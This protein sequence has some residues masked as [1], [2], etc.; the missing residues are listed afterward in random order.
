MK[1]KLNQQQ[2]E[3]YKKTTTI[4]GAPKW[5]G[6]WKA[7]GKEVKLQLSLRPHL[8]FIQNYYCI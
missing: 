4:P 6:A 2:D 1:L 7:D 3:Y 5:R 8:N